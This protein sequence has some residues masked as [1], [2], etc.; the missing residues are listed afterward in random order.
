MSCVQLGA[1]MEM[2]KPELTHRLSI[3]ADIA[4]SLEFAT[5]HGT[6]RAMF[7]ITGGQV[8]GDGFTGIILPGGAD[9]ARALPDGSYEIEARYCIRFDDG[10]PV[11]IVNAGRMYP[12]PDGSFV[13]R[14]RASFE[15][16]TGRFDWLSDGVFFG[17]ALSESEEDKH[18]FIELWQASLPEDPINRPEAS[19]GLRL[20]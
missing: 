16:P 17:T 2:A 8:L 5:H 19:N 9:F 12:R 3:R 1:K 20:P 10:T 4:P 14:T 11:M 6:T 13:G 15:T 18:I 7:P